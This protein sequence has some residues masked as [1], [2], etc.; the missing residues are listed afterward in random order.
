MQL[1]GVLARSCCHAVPEH[2]P[3]SSGAGAAAVRLS[4]PR[5]AV[6]RSPDVLRAQT[7]LSLLPARSALF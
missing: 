4:L 6:P 7:T 1:G 3:G 2:L 5:Q